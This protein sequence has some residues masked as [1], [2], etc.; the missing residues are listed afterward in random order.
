MSSAWVG[1]TVGNMKALFAWAALYSSSPI[2]PSAASPALPARGG[3]RWAVPYLHPRACRYTQRGD[4]RL[5]PEYAG[6]A[7]KARRTGCPQTEANQPKRKSRE[8]LM[9]RDPPTEQ[10]HGITGSSQTA[11]LLSWFSYRKKRQ[12]FGLLEH[13]VFRPMIGYCTQKG[14]LPVSRTTT[15]CRRWHRSAQDQLTLERRCGDAYDGE[16]IYIRKGLISVE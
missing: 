12:A 10:D 13:S 16:F 2:L 15:P 3:A 6:I 8:S 9:I 5:H 14:H 11:P 7:G 1:Q 4:Q